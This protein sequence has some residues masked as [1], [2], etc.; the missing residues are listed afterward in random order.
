[1]LEK[2]RS[3]KCALVLEQTAV[4]FAVV[5]TSRGSSFHSLRPAPKKVLSPA[6]TSFTLIV[7]GSIVQRNLVVYISWDQ[8][9]K[10]LEDKN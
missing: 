5:L 10:H 9:M 8:A 7:E 4:R 3:K 1:M 2:V 6:W